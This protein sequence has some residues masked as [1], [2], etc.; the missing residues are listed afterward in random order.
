[1][2]RFALLF[3][4]LSLLLSACGLN[5]YDQPKA[6]LYETLPYN[7][8]VASSRLLPEGT[9]SRNR[10][11]VSESFYTGLVDNQL[12]TELPFPVTMD[13][14]KRGQERYNIYCSP[15]HNYSG[16]GLGVIVQRGMVRPS[17]FHE[18]R[19][20]DA[21][22]GY[23]YSAITN[24]FGRMYSYASRIPPEDRWAITAYIKAVQLSQYA[25]ASDAPPPAEDEGAAEDAPETTPD[26]APD[27]APDTGPEDAPDNAPENTP[28]DGPSMP[29][30]TAQQ[31][32]PEEASR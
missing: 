31:D 15:C 26:S 9:V 21:P 13:V 32:N 18:Q 2:K 25:A 22:V 3:S 11:P 6:E 14:L 12:A 7:D 16:N 1:M 8:G 27:S 20:R 4:A 30:N 29:A 10:G 24:G 23:F 5:M 19:L 17:S 28:D